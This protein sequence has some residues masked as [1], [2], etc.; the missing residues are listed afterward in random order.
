MAELPSLTLLLR[1]LQAQTFPRVSVSHRCITI[2]HKTINLKSNHAWDF[3]MNLGAEHNC[4]DEDDLIWSVSTSYSTSTSNRQLMITNHLKQAK[5][6]SGEQKVNHAF[7]VKPMPGSRKVCLLG[8]KG[9]KA[10]ELIQFTCNNLLLI[11]MH[12]NYWTCIDTIGQI[13]EI[14][15]R[16]H[17]VLTGVSVEKISTKRLF[18]TNQV[19]LMLVAPQK[20]SSVLFDHRGQIC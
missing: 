1:N 2:N 11:K 4:D 5:S 6:G 13:R 18:E 7:V 3:H 20:I 9:V 14:P 12:G 10:I 15:Q 17:E 16:L 19:L 8:T